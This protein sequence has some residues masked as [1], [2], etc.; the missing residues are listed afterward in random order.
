MSAVSRPISG[1]GGHPPS[2]PDQIPQ[3]PK[4]L[5]REIHFHLSRPVPLTVHVL[6]HPLSFLR[7]VP[8]TVFDPSGMQ[9]SGGDIM[10]LGLPDAWGG[11]SP[12]GTSSEH[13]PGGGRR[14]SLERHGGS[15]GQR[16]SVEMPSPP[17]SPSPVVPLGAPLLLLIDLQL[18]TQ[19]GG[20]GRLRLNAWAGKRLLGQGSVLLLPPG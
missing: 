19:G 16:R 4:H 8:L 11:G 17:T 3:S 7:S 1:E 13:T 14:R 20:P 15:R 18:N 9:S 2:S 5:D 6:H 10:H 12:S